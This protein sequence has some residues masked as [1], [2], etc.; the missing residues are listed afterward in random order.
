METIVKKDM[1]GIHRTLLC[2]G[3]VKLKCFQKTKKKRH[4]SLFNDV[5]VVSRILNKREFKI[6]CIIPLHLLWVVVDDVAQRRKNEICTCKTLYLHCP[7]GHF[8]ATFRSQEQKD[9]WHYF[10]QRSIHEAKKGI[11]T[12]LSL[13]IHTEDIPTCDSTLSVTATNLD[14][15]NDIIEKLL[16]MIRMRNS[17]DYQLWFS[18]SREEAPRALQGFKYPHIIIMTNFQNTCN[19]SNSR[20]LTAFPALPGMFVQD[21]NSDA[22]GHFF[23]K[24]RQPAINQQQSAEESHSKIQRPVLT[25]CFHR[26]SVPHQDQVCTV[27][28]ANNGKLFGTELSCI[29][30]EG[31]WPKLIVDILS[32]I[33]KQGPSTEGIFVIAPEETSC[34]ALKEKLESGEELDLKKFSVHEVAWI[35]KEFLGHI[36]GCVLTSTLYEQW[37]DVP[38]KVNNKD[39]LR[40]VKSLLDKLPLENAALLGNLFRILHT[41]ASSSSINKMKPYNISTGIA[42]SILWL[43]SYRKVIN[44]IDQK[45]SLI[46]FMIENSPEIFGID[47]VWYETSLFYPQEAKASCSQNATS[48]TG[49]IKETE[50]ELSSCPSGRTHTPGHYARQISPAAPLVCESIIDAQKDEGNAYITQHEPSPPA[51][52][53]NRESMNQV[54]H[55]TFYNR[56]L[57]MT[58][59]SVD[60][61]ISMFP[62][63]SHSKKAEEIIRRNNFRFLFNHTYL[64]QVVSFTILILCCIIHFVINYNKWH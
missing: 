8:W 32:V 62:S 35:L 30:H 45:I 42:S 44:D 3:P 12:N 28:T 58:K 13:K 51:V 2:Q 23:L 59:E 25:S 19:G 54:Q 1:G 5:L 11:K 27:P 38:N 9:Q 56:N 55:T 37:L 15:V 50:P 47:M 52:T 60:P 16:P 41:I 64:V 31:K 4:L 21:L 61:C 43:P 24:P 17:E 63:T 26:G 57:V 46:T 7:N 34:K 49:N 53:Q 18:H 14:T 22:Q 10:L 33:R 36:K 48:N 39:K 40:A 20:I 6:K 29:Y